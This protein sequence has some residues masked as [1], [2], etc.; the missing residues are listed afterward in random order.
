[1]EFLR[2]LTKL[3]QGTALVMSKPF[4]QIDIIKNLVKFLL[5]PNDVDVKLV[6]I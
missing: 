3:P 2:K 1:M 4:D 5:G 6:A